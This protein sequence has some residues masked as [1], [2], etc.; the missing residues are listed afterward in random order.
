MKT[1]IVYTDEPMKIGKQLPRT[2]LPSPED[3]VLYY[4][5]KKITLTLTAQTL[6]F[7]KKEAKKHQVPYQKMIRN[8]LDLYV[9]QASQTK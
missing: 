3:L 1:N 8:L 4:P 6:E 9:A 2:F 5:T 7:F